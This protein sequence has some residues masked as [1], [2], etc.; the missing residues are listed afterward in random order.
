MI[1]KEIRKATAT[2]IEGVL[3]LQAKYLVS[4][5]S[6]TEKKD[7]F[8]TTPFTT[9]QIIQILEE[10]GLF[11][12]IADNK[13]IA[14]VFAGSWDYYSQWPIFPYMVSRFP[15]Q[16]FNGVQITGSNSFQYG[17]IC[18]DQHFRGSGLLNEIFEVMRLNLKERY[19][20]GIT[21]IN[22]VN[23]RSFKAHTEKLNWGVID[24]FDYN[25][26]SFY[27]MVIDMNVSVL[28]PE[29]DL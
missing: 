9:T 3:E 21:F 14:Y 6:E 28:S 2:D 7:G 1:M 19:P 15:G 20:I 23:G 12:A 25:S 22:K 5:L 18:I 26:N 8:V 10:D 4:N 16:A 27:M 29:H 13:V 24:E 11:V 17:P